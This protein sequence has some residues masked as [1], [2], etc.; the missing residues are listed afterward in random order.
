MTKKT[1]MDNWMKE[2]SIPHNNGKIKW[3]VIAP[4]QGDSGGGGHYVGEYDMT[5][6]YKGWDIVFADANKWADVY[7]D[8][9]QWWQVC[10]Q[11]M[12][13]DMMWNVF[14]ALQESNNLDD[15]WINW[16]EYKKELEDE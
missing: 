6:W 14:T 5:D 2:S 11:D 4:L 12:V 1:D 13:K 10:R 15:I 9:D 7:L 8:D 16:V 3:Y